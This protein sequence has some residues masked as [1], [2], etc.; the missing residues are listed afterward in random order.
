MEEFDE[1]IKAL[2]KGFQ[3]RHPSI[4]DFIADP[5]IDSLRKNERFKNL[6]K[7][8]NLFQWAE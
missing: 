8:M 1:A 6:L 3:D 2:E 5:L 7:R 4:L